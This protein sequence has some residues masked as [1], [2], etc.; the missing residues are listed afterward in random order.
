MRST[1]G[2]L[3]GRANPHPRSPC[4]LLRTHNGGGPPMETPMA[5]KQSR[6][7]VSERL[8]PDVLEVVQH[9]QPAGGA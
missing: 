6:E 7:Q 1:R 4:E 2:A 8:D 9:E 5:Q 3:P